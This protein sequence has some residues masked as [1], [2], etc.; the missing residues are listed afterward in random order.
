MCVF[1]VCLL[2]FLRRGEGRR[3]R[4]LNLSLVGVGLVRTR[5][6]EGSASSYCWYA[7]VCFSSACVVSSRANV[8]CPAEVTVMP[9][10]S[11][12][13]PRLRRRQKR[14]QLKLAFQGGYLVSWA[15]WT[16]EV[17]VIAVACAC[18]LRRRRRRGHWNHHEVESSRPPHPHPHPHPHSLPGRLLPAATSAYTSSKQPRV[19][20]N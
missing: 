10:G 11:L 2:W 15:D 14:N 5:G 8:S 1:A 16:V 12:R 6:K 13:R 9:V 4:L 19:W 17:R 7:C 18:L 20:S 3:S